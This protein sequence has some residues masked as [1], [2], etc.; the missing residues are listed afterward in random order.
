MIRLA[1]PIAS[2]KARGEERS[3]SLH[4][5]PFSSREGTSF[6]ERT[7]ATTRRPSLRSRSTIALPTKPVAPVTKKSILPL[8]ISAAR[9]TQAKRYGKS[10]RPRRQP[11]D[12]T[13]VFDPSSFDL[14]KG[15]IDVE[16]AAFI[17]AFGLPSPS[18]PLV[19]STCTDRPCAQGNAAGLSRART[20]LDR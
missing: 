10:A 15:S 19:S 20:S 1:P 2:A 4:S 11:Y 7:R 13:S 3:P 16:G 8:P 17:D 6:S 12:T 9:H 14:K 18:P 5:T